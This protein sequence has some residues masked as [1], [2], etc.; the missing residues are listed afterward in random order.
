MRTLQVLL[1]AFALT[2]CISQMPADSPAAS[3]EGSA[4]APAIIDDASAVPALV[5]VPAWNVGDAWSMV[6]R[7]QGDERRFHLV[8]TG[9]D[10][11]GY[12]VETT[13][14]RMAGYDAMVDVSYIGRI[15][16]A[17][18]AGSQEG[19]P[20]QF[21]AFPLEDGRTWSARWDGLTVAL[22]ATK[23]ARG[24]DILGLVDGEPYVAY[25]YVPDLRWW[26]KVEFL[27]E[28]YTLSVE[29]VETGWTG[30]TVT[31]TAKKVF[32]GGPAAPV[33]SSATGSFTIDE[34]Q[35]YGV[36]TLVGGGTRWAR[37][38]QLIDPSGAPYG[39]TSISNVDT[40]GAGP[41]RVFLSEQF[42]PTPG[43]WRVVAPAVHDAEGGFWLRVHQVALTP[44]S[45]PAA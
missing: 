45:V 27:R 10:A 18:L 7:W 8:V 40:E 38:F 39:S 23:G 41:R 32:E 29:R 24:F 12:V 36:A 9:V 17:D 31:A 14:E 4:I 2:G 44:R 42:P 20:V 30:T 33:A 5:D 11:E 26:S 19:T 28:G 25:D 1:V 16:A 6:S 15:R 43:E 35:S 22:T 37:A 3:M 34:G 13:D 21:F